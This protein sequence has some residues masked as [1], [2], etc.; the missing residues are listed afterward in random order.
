MRHQL[1]SVPRAW[2]LGV[3]LGF[4]VS[5]AGC[6]GPDDEPPQPDAQ[7]L[8]VT[9]WEQPTDADGRARTPMVGVD[10][11]GRVS[12]DRSGRCDETP[13]YD[14]AVQSGIDNGYATL[15]ALLNYSELG[16]AEP[17]VQTAVPIQLQAGEGLYG[18]EVD[19]ASDPSAPVHI[20]L[21][22][23]TTSE[24]LNLDDALR[25]EGTAGLTA[26]PIERVEASYDGVRWRA[27]FASL[28][29]PMGPVL[30]LRPVTGVVVEFDMIAGRFVRADLGARVSIDTA[31]GVGMDAT[32]EPEAGTRDLL[33]GL[34]IADLDPD[35]DGIACAAI[36][37]GV[38]LEL[39]SLPR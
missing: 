15:L 10:L 35:E 11:D 6:A 29:V 36:S 27:E 21:L 8:L 9:F 17:G 30:G 23:F 5:G 18:F 33:L 20:T 22:S 28:D 37:F 12:P 7:R 39:E 4:T 24:P 32:G 1:V 34:G 26:T 16:G 31:V 2:F 14:G 19:P 3:C 13:D 38:G 25:L